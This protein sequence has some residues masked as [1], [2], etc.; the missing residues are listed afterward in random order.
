MKL[1]LLFAFSSNVL[2]QFLWDYS[3][4]HLN[5][6]S[7]LFYLLSV[8]TT[9]YKGFK[10]NYK[11]KTLIVF[12]LFCSASNSIDEFFYD[13]TTLEFNDLIRI[14]TI[15]IATLKCKKYFKQFGTMPNK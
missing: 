10:H 13:A 1:G 9:T 14:T 6:L 8:Y 12:S 7:F 4:Y 5:S 15:I 11:T 2:E 3:F